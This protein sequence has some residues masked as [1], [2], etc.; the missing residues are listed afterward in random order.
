MA[1]GLWLAPWEIAAAA[2]ALALLF[3]RLPSGGRKTGRRKRSGG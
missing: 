3:V 2:Y 1:E